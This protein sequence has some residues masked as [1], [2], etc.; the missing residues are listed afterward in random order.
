[1]KSSKCFYK[2]KEYLQDR[3]EEKLSWVADKVNNGGTL[4]DVD[5]IVDA[6]FYLIKK[7]CRKDFHFKKPAQVELTDNSMCV[8]VDGKEYDFHA[9]I[10]HNDGKG[11][12]CKMRIEVLYIPEQMRVIVQEKLTSKIEHDW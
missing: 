3:L 11:T 8:L 5:T 12:E 1:M 7:V 4:E 10:H 2:L 6:Y 9:E